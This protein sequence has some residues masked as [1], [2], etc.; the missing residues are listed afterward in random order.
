MRP[1]RLTPENRDKSDAQRII[2]E[3]FNEAG[4]INPG[5]PVKK[6]VGR[7]GTVAAS[8]RPGR[9]TPE[10]RAPRRSR[11]PPCAG[12]NEAGAINPGKPSLAKEILRE[13]LALQ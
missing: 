10:N 1:G 2:A 9:L 13:A 11:R 6:W 3:S 5:K 12:F 7:A 4:A 8:M